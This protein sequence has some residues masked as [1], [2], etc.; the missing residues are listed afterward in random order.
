M[1]L[2]KKGKDF[3]KREEGCILHT[4]HCAAGVPTI[5]Y[6][7]T[8]GVKDGMKITQEQADKY[9]DGDA[10][11]FEAGVTKLLGGTVVT[12]NMFNA[13]VSFAYNLGLGALANSS[14]LKL[15]KADVNDA[16][17]VKAFKI[18]CKVS[19]KP[20]VDILARRVREAVMYFS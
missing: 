11:Y 1:R 14:L 3:V 18:W 9:F 12:Q 19:G 15:V 10:L 2:D 17:I 13:L 8:K 20:N 7:T 4:Y 6:G 16:G 5:G